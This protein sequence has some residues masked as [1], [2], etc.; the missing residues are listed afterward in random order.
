MTEID[1][2]TEV[3]DHVNHHYY[4]EEALQ[5]RLTKVYIHENDLSEDLED[6][7]V[8]LPFEEREEAAKKIKKKRD[9]KE[10][11]DLLAKHMKR[12]SGA[13]MAKLENAHDIKHPSMWD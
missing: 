11:K 1:K 4:S 13:E 5:A 9:E 3:D 7:L 6:L 10:D 8:G 12:V 2:K